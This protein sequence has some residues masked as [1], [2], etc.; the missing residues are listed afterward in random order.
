MVFTFINYL[1]LKYI[2]KK[3]GSYKMRLFL[4]DKQHDL[5]VQLKRTGMTNT[6]MANTY[7]KLREKELKVLE[8]EKYIKKM[9]KIVKGINQELITLG[10]KG[11]KYININVSNTRYAIAR[12]N[13]AEHDLKLTQM[14]NEL[15]KEIQD[16]WVS[17][18]EIL[19]D[20]K[21]KYPESYKNMNTCIDAYVVVDNE[22]IG[23]ESIG[24]TYTKKIMEE[25]EQIAKHFVGCKKLESF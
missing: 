3:K 18:S 10:P 1:N 23:L 7:Q 25:K 13:H 16:T 9:K 22:K 2:Y 8:A 4:N 20:L 12:T 17:E 24:Y 6:H 5:L 14:Y 19:H 15:P 11:K 21:S